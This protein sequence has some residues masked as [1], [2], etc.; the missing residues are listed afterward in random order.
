M[1]KEEGA[2]DFSFGE[3]IKRQLNRTLAEAIS[4]D[5]G[6]AQDA[7]DPDVIFITSLENGKVYHRPGPMFIFGR[8]K[9][10]EPQIA[11]KVWHVPIFTSVEELIGE[12]MKKAT[13]AESFTMHASGREDIDVTNTAGRPFVMELAGVTNREISLAELE[14]EISKDKRI[15][16]KL[17]RR[18][19]RSFVALVSDSH[20]DKSYRVYIS[21]KEG[22]DEKDIERIC[23]LGGKMISQKNPER[24]MRRRANIERRRKAYSIT[25]GKDEKGYYADIECEAGTYVKELVNGDNGRTQPSF[26]SATNKNMACENLV[27]T[28]IRDKFLDTVL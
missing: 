16:V 9:K 17:E 18:V 22:I 25:A 14:K 27:V 15:S 11:Q 12:P 21:A 10:L 13:M 26:S 20:F 4:K 28:R 6:M 19:P 7:D 24:M 8:Y 2:F 3:S 5:T 23:A 1:I